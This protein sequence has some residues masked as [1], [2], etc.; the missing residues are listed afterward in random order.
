MLVAEWCGS[1]VTSIGYTGKVL[2]RIGREPYHRAGL[3]YHTAK[4]ETF[5]LFSGM[6][7]VLFVRDG[8]VYKFLLQADRNPPSVHVPA[9]AIHSVQTQG[10]SVMFEAA[11]YAPDSETIRVED[12]YSVVDAIEIQPER[13]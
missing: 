13:L 8:Q 1:A 2:H 9:G 3:Q 10:N 11:E 6:A 5:Y 7:W 12:D 4:D